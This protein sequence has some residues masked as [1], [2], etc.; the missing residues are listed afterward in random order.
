MVRL[1]LSKYNGSKTFTLLTLGLSNQSTEYHHS[2]SDSGWSSLPDPIL[3][4]YIEG[5]RRTQHHNVLRVVRGNGLHRR[6]RTGDE[7]KTQYDVRFYEA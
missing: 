4:R 7:P 5:L 6:L 1:D 2:P 3:D